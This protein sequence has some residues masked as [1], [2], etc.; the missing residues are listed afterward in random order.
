MPTDASSTPP[1]L[2]IVVYGGAAAL[3]VASA[4]GLVSMLNIARVFVGV[5]LV[6][7]FSA[8]MILFTRMVY[9]NRES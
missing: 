9:K 1:R 5:L 7:V 3:T 8:M 4:V 6:V 2:N